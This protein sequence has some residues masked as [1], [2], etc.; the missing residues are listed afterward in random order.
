MKN[1]PILV[2]G[3]TGFLGSHLLHYLI[4]EGYSNI[5]ALKRTNSKMTGVETIKDKL[6]WIEGDILDVGS[7]EDAMEGIQ[8]VY[9]CAALVSFDRRDAQKMIKVNVEGTAN[10]VN[11]ALYKKIDKLVYVSSIS[12]LG[13]QKNG[14]TID[15]KIKWEDN[16]NNSNYSI[17]KFLAEQEVW[18]GIVE[19]LNATIVNPSVILGVGDWSKG[20]P[21]IFK[22]VARKVPFYPLGTTGFVDVHNVVEAMVNLMESEIS[23]ER[24]IISGENLSIKQ[25]L[26]WI[27]AA[28]G[29][30]PPLT[31]LR[32]W[33][34][35]ILWRIEWF[36]SRLIRKRA[37][38]TK[39]MVSDTS[40]TYY[41]DNKKS[42]QFIIP[43]Y[44]PIEQSIQEIGK[45]F[46]KEYSK[47]KA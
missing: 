27:A 32:P 7:L 19:G 35:G 26:D 36:R 31:P 14:S 20:T 43:K 28:I 17:S 12:A 39:E 11:I 23:E 44:I 29:T 1:S 41:F 3:G 22:Q 15:E 25:V 37:F 10:V 24:F 2:T 47:I 6:K 45:F 40:R 42:L 46:L 33:M 5:R 34:A 18:R 38:I 8:Q 30:S 21:A 9:H 16:K 13:K 4:E